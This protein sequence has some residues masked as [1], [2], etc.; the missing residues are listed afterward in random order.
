MR[1]QP[2]VKKDMLLNG[3]YRLVV[4][5]IVLLK[6]LA[7]FLRASTPPLTLGFFFVNLSYWVAPPLSVIALCISAIYLM[8]SIARYQE[9]CRIRNLFRKGKYTQAVKV[10][11]KMRA[12]WCCR[13]A[14]CAA[15]VNF[16]EAREYYSRMGYR[17]FH[18]FP[19]STFT[20]RSPFFSFRFWASL[21][22]SFSK[23]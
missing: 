20:R 19:D 12:S 16:Y 23:P 22:P 2:E 3:I 6:E 17:W 14:A 18:V 15:S 8:D 10:I 9:Y 1:R 11:E 13:H 21:I 5:I 4:P 7:D